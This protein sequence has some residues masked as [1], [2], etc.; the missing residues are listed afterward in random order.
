MSSCSIGVLQQGFVVEVGVNRIHRRAEVSSDDK[1]EETVECYRWRLEAMYSLEAS[2]RI[3]TRPTEYRAHDL[4]TTSSKMAQDAGD[5]QAKLEAV[6]TSL[7][8]NPVIGRYQ[9]W[10]ERSTV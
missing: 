7:E 10:R 8:K 3:C 2:R 6:V 1:S 4:A 9:H 5:D